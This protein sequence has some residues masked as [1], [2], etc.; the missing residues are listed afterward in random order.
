MSTFLFLLPS[1]QISLASIKVKSSRSSFTYISKPCF[2]TISLRPDN[3]PLMDFV[4]SALSRYPPVARQL[5]A[6]TI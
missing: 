2:F 1:S 6:S 4:V 3:L 5:F